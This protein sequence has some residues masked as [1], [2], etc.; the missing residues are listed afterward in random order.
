[1]SH[2]INMDEQIMDQGEISEREKFD[3]YPLGAKPG[4]LH[5]LLKT[6]RTFED[7]IPSFHPIL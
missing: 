6:R 2:L 3:L 5:E 1:M 7:E 4:V